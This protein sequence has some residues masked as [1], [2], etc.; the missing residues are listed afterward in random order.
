MFSLSS[1]EEKAGYYLPSTIKCFL[2][3]YRNEKQKRL[4]KRIE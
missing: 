3:I 2:S 4:L 1:S